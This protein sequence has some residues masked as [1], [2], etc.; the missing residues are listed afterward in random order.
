M[1]EGASLSCPGGRSL[2]S[3]R[4]GEPDVRV[5]RENPTYQPLRLG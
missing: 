1:E 2:L 3:P 4:A 5:K